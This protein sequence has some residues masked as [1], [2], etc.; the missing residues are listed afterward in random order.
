MARSTYLEVINKVKVLLREDAA[1]TSTDDEYTTMLAQFVDHALEVVQG[2]WD[3]SFLWL[4]GTE[5]TSTSITELD[6]L[7]ITPTCTIKWIYNSTDKV[8]MIQWPYSR[9][10]QETLNG[11][12]SSTPMYYATDIVAASSGYKNIYIY[13][14]PT[15][16]TLIYYQAYVPQVISSDSTYLAV[17]DAPVVW[18]A[19]AM[20]LEERG[21]DGGATYQRA[22]VMHQETL[23]TAIS[24]DSVS[25]PAGYNDWQVI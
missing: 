8:E 23:G 19:Y 6:D 4:S 15:T 10:I 21:E 17:D 12:S 2:S 1:T 20:A 11:A 14:T 5:T 18:L 9:I 3:W 7:G 16:S 22:M 24:R 25:Q 13:P